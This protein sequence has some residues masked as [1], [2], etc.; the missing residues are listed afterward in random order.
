M[1]ASTIQ[2]SLILILLTWA[3]FIGQEQLEQLMKPHVVKILL[4]SVAVSAVVLGILGFTFAQSSTTEHPAL[5]S[6]STDP[7]VEPA[8]RTDEAVTLVEMQAS[9]TPPPTAQATRVP[10]ATPTPS[11]EPTPTPR[12]AD[13][14]PRVG[15]QIGHLYSNELPDELA[16]LR[17]STGAFFNGIEEFEVNLAI[18]EIVA[19]QLEAQGVIVDIIPATVPIQYEADAFIAIHADGGSSSKAS[20]FKLATPWRTSEASQHLHDVMREEYAA[21]TGMRWDSNITNNMRGYYAFNYRRHQ[22]A[23]ARTTPAVIVE[24][25]FLTNANDRA[26]IVNN[27]QLIATAI[28][29]GILR[30]LNERDPLDGGALLPPDYRP[31]RPISPDGVAILVQP[32][33]NAAVLTHLPANETISPFTEKDGWYQVFVR[34]DGE[35]NSGWI[36][37]DLLQNSFGP[38][39]TPLASSDP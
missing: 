38:T 18:G 36:R 15:I 20:G 33:D 1:R 17:T 29:N 26:L 7:L 37:K 24:T 4:S 28:S 19:A 13:Q 32:R 23:I 21:L 34:I 22:H 31:L 14:P 39:P 11:V 12:P 27:P 3:R 9:A 25:G 6:S 10:T 35:R 5:A 30:Y 16:R 8:A 2:Q